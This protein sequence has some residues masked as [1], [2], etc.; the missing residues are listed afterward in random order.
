MRTFLIQ[1][2]SQTEGKKS[3]QFGKTPNSHNEIHVWVM[4]VSTE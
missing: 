2:V 4:N 1:T 3:N